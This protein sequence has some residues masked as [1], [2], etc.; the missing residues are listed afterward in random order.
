MPVPAGDES[1]NGTWVL[2]IGDEGGEG[3]T[4]HDWS[5]EIMSRFD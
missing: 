2:T 3:G 4:L 1:V 5:L